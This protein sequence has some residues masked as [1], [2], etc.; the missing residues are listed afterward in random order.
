MQ[1]NQNNTQTA[2]KPK[3]AVIVTGGTILSTYNPE[4]KQIKLDKTGE[5]L[6][7]ELPALKDRYSIELIEFS[8]IPSPHFTPQ[9]ILELVDKIEEMIRRTDICGVVVLQGTDTL[10]EVSYLCYLLAK[11]DKPVV[12]TGSMKSMHELYADSLGNLYGAFFVAASEQARNR[13]VMVYFNQNILSPR[14]VVKTNANNVAS[15]QAPE[16][17]PMGAVANEQIYFYHPHSGQSHY[18]RSDKITAN[19]QLIKASFNADDLLLRACIDQKVD[20]IVI[21]GLGAGN[22]PPS[23]IP[24]IQEAIELK[25]PVV[26]VSRCIGGFAATAYDYHGG[27]AHLKRLGVISGQNLGGVRAR[28]KLMVLLSKSNDLE[29]I[30]QEFGENECEVR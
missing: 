23:F 20:G 2:E 1:Q 7:S 30:K 4:T 11:A 19:V 9:I 8:N 27:G 21:E 5:Q 3:V 14:Y 17:G 26:V 24:A 6:L 16:T 29:Y 15:F 25:I 10:E 12:F 18:D 13:G 22:V 28:L